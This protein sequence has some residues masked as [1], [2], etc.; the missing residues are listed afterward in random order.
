[1]ISKKKL[2]QRK[3]FRE[4]L[5]I[6]DEKVLDVKKA[7]IKLIADDEIFIMVN[8]TSNYWI[9][10]YGRP[11]NNLH[12]DFRMHKTG[13]AHYTL[14]G[15]DK[16]IETYTDKLV[17]EHFLEKPD[18]CN[19]IWHIDMDRDNCYYRNLIW[20]NNEEYMDLQRGIVLVEDLGRQQEYVPYITLKSNTAYSIWNGI[21]I[22]CYRDN[23]VYDGAYMCDLWKND[24]DSFV[25]WWHS[26]Y[27]ECDGESMAVDKDLLYPG[28][29]EYAPDKCCIIPQTLN[30]MLSNCKKHKTKWKSSLNL[31]L[32]VRYDRA[33]K[34]Y[35][36]EF[37]PFGHDEVIRLSYWETPEQ[38]FEEYKMHKQADILI[39]A[40]KYKSKVPRKVYEAL[41]KVEVKPY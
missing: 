33:I 38:A 8:G 14:S 20:V 22:R 39:M 6:A 4:Y 3:E 28:N 21:Y 11:V 5:S 31:P 19:K 18:K 26:E 32:G 24:K 10:N 37:R 30:T 12:G 13:Y 35:Y 34:M 9:S 7:G 23:R 25:E 1:M 17:A 16:K 40:D 27:Y 36:G 29:K 41:L 2:Q 15:I